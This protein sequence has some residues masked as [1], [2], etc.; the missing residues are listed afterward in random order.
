MCPAGVACVLFYKDADIDGFGDKTGTLTNGRAVA[1]CTGDPAPP[2]FVA[3]NTDCNDSD[4]NTK[5]S[6]TGFFGS[7]SGG[8]VASFDYNCDGVLEK[9]TAEISG[10]SCGFCSFSGFPFICSKVTSCSGTHQ[11]I[12]ACEWAYQV[13]RWA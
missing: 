7:L 10:G 6:Q 11:V 1:G 8:T 12:S 3:S 2:G 4:F 13:S 9:E 5:P